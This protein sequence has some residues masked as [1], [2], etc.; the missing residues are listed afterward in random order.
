MTPPSLQ[1]ERCEQ[2]C[3]RDRSNNIH[4]ESSLLAKHRKKKCDRF[5]RMV[6]A[7]QE[8]QTKQSLKHLHKYILVARP[9]L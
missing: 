7:A 3:K 5:C 2:L 1:H 9:D 4:I 8:K 6:R